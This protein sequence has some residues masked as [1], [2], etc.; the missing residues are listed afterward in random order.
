LDQ[1]RAPGIFPGEEEQVASPRVVEEE[2]EGVVFFGVLWDDSGENPYYH[3]QEY[4]IE[5]VAN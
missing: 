3:M 5:C 2:C 1:E 4:W